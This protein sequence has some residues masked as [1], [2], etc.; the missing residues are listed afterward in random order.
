MHTF[1][2]TS[3][4]EWGEHLKQEETF[5]QKCDITCEILLDTEQ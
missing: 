3:F 5:S 2:K 1:I 4:F